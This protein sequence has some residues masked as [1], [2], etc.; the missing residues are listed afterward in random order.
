MGNF[1]WGSGIWRFGLLEW[2]VRGREVTRPALAGEFLDGGT[3]DGP[4]R[5]LAG[6]MYFFWGILF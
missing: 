5:S 4:V 6:R 3:R 1:G 2:L